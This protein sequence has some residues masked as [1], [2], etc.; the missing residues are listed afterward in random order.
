MRCAW[1]G[2]LLQQP[3]SSYLLPAVGLSVGLPGVSVG[4]FLLWKLVW[5]CPGWGETGV[6]CTGAS[7]GPSPKP[8]G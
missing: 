1:G 6:T 8:G 4:A 7:I 5:R 3:C 2:Q